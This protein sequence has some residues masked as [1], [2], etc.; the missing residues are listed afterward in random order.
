M[1]GALLGLDSDLSSCA[2]DDQACG[3]HVGDGSCAHSHIAAVDRAMEDHVDARRSLPDRHWTRS[4]S[5]MRSWTLASASPR[6]FNS[7][8]TRG[9]HAC[10]GSKRASSR[11]SRRMSQSC[12]KSAS[13]LAYI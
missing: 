11:I 3:A 8:S 13:I 5:L 2:D 4:P 6:F 1:R 7:I 10:A 12:G 9:I